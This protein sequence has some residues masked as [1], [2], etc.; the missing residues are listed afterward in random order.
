ME[1]PDFG[2]RK[3]QKR[4]AIPGVAGAEKCGTPHVPA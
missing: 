1:A 4:A 3:E 2:R